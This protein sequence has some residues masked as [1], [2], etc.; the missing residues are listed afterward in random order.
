MLD[1]VGFYFV[2]D[3]RPARRSEII[4]RQGH[5]SEAV[6]TSSS[7]MHHV[8]TANHDLL[9][10]K[11]RPTILH[12]WLIRI[13][14]KANDPAARPQRARIDLGQSFPEALHPEPI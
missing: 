1:F 2:A 9:R 13:G 5:R 4:R 6:I 8:A 3:D 10:R 12:R 14:K 7:V 11:L